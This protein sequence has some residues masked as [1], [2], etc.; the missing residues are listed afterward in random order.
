MPL[1]GGADNRTAAP[2]ASDAAPAAPEPPLEA[3]D[4]ELEDEDAFDPLAYD[5]LD[6]VPIQM[7]ST[8]IAPVGQ[9]LSRQED[10]TY[11]RSDAPTGSRDAFFLTLAFGSQKGWNITSFDAQ[12][13]YLQSDGITRLLLIRMPWQSPP[14]GTQPGQVL[15]ATGSIHVW[16]MRCGSGVVPPFQGCSRAKDV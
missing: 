11:I 16:N 12:S 3:V 14:P 10:K 2:A 9:P 5:H 13:A 7:R 8:P 1:D 15:V 4:E 6:D